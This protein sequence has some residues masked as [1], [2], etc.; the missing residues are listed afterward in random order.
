MEVRELSMFKASELELLQ[1]LLVG[2]PLTDS[3]LHL[4]QQQHT[5][6]EAVLL[7]SRILRQVQQVGY[8]SI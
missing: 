4:L 7:R 1:H 5:N 2:V 6:L 3:T 8:V